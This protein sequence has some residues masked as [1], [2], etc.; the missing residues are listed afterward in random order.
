[1]IRF[2]TESGATYLVDDEGKRFKREGPDVG[3]RHA[4]GEW[5]QFSIRSDFQP[6]YGAIFAYGDG[7]G[8]RTTPVIE[9][10]EVG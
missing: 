7:T 4:D 2:T 6:G 9:A 8:R 3:L 5:H 1:M 10:T